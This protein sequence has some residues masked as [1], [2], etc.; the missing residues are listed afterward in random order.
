MQE[1][2]PRVAVCLSGEVRFF[3]DELVMSGF[4]TY[5]ESWNPDVFISTWDHVGV[6]MNHGYIPPKEVK[7]REDTLHLHI[8]NTYKN[9]KAVEFENYNEWIDAIPQEDYNVVYSDTLSSRTINSYPQLYK[10]HKANN[11]KLA[12]EEK[13]GFK[14]DVVLRV[15][16]DNL[17]IRPL[18]LE[19]MSKGV[20]Y[21]VNL[22]GAYYPNR[23]YDVFF[24]GGSEEMDT[25][26]NAYVKFKELLFDPFNNGLCPRDTC[27]LLYIQAT[28]AGLICESTKNR[29]CDI[30]RGQTF[31]EYCDLL[32]SWGGLD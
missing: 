7:E 3:T 23:I 19:G 17:F 20:I 18:D 21:D 27:R 26:C 13:L 14:Y 4:E 28:K 2:K 22:K 24:Y 10:I 30:Y 11:L 8:E 9:I 25:V 31:E 32:Q 12:Y 29:P 15:R 6:S 5:I 16:P 1:Y